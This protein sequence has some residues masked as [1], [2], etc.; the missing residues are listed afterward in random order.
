M[1]IFSPSFLFGYQTAA[2]KKILI[3]PLLNVGYAFIRYSWADAEGNTK[4]TFNEQGAFIQP[5]LF[6]AYLFS[7]KI[8]VGLNG[9]FEIIFQHFGSNATLED[10]NIRIACMGIG[11]TY[12]L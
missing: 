10:S 6:V 12:S 7:K 8:S 1:N 3:H 11:M 2:F 5:S 9:S 4:P